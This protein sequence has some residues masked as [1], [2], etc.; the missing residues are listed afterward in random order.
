MKVAGVYDA[1]AAYERLRHGRL[2]Y[3][4]HKQLHLDDGVEL[5]DYLFSELEIETASHLLDA[6]CGVGDTA[7]RFCQQNHENTAL[8]ISLSQKEIDLATQASKGMQLHDRCQFVLQSY[9]DPMNNSFDL[10]IAIESLKHSRDL[11]A[12][13]QNLSRTLKPGGKIGL[14]DDFAKDT[15]AEM[16]EALRQTFEKY[17]SLCT[18]YTNQDFLTAFHASGLQL[19]KKNDLTSSMQPKKRNKL[20]SKYKR[21]GLI[22]KLLPSNAIRNTM[23]IFQAGIALE[24]FYSRDAFSYELLIFEKRSPESPRIA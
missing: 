5:V 13:V 15:Y 20:E 9:D 23:G 14:A 8:G 24:Y 19:I 1:L 18:V 10:I 22:R 21:F 6:G 7:L 12:T 11:Q 2:S 3:P 4:I 17:W 16:P